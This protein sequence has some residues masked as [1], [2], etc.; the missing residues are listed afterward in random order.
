[1]KMR[2]ARMAAPAPAPMSADDMRESVDV[3][4][5]TVEMGEFFRYDVGTPITIKRGQSAMVPIL[6]APIE[7]KKEHVFNAEKMDVNPVVTMR[8]NNDTGAT[9]ERG[10]VVVMDEGTYVGEA[11]LPYTTGETENHIAYSVD[12]GMVVNHHTTSGEEL[13]VI[14]IRDIER[15]YGPGYL[16]K[17]VLTWAETT[18]EAVNKKT[19][20]LDLVIE[21]V[22][23]PDWKVDTDKTPEPDEETEGFNRWRF[24]VKPKTTMKFIVRMQRTE[25]RYEEI[26]H[27]GLDVLKGYLKGKFI[28]KDD[29]KRLQEVIDLQMKQNELHEE[30]RKF[31]QKR[32]RIYHEEDRLRKNMEAMGSVDADHDLWKRTVDKLKDYEDALENNDEQVKANEAEI[33]RLEKEINEKLEALLE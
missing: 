28:E 29:H 32:E 23:A 26:R 33:G 30:I 20:P 18:Y 7:C 21:H 27:L 25:M 5:A 22:R 24:T 1:M 2:A 15:Y 14:S 17:E 13:R 3:Q 12:L 19:E 9:L 4:T 31:T 6:Q 11:I 16:R 10:P 8:L